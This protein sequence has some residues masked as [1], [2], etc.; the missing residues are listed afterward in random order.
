MHWK[1]RNADRILVGTPE[2][3]QPIWTLVVDERTV[4][5]MD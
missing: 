1:T 4:L 3:K 5:K 2:E